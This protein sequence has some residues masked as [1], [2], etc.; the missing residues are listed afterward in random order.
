MRAETLQLSG[1]V[2]SWHVQVQSEAPSSR[3]AWVAC[4]CSPPVH[5]V[6]VSTCVHAAR[7]SLHSL[8]QYHTHQGCVCGSNHPWGMW[9]DPRNVEGLVAD[10]ARVRVL[11][12]LLELVLSDLIVV[13]VLDGLTIAE[14]RIIGHALCILR[15]NLQPWLYSIT[16][17]CPAQHRRI[18]R[19]GCP[20]MHHCV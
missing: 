7:K 10:D 3:F 19:S 18:T 13:L 16:C 20:R 2:A 4:A 5:V 12:V 17:V 8:R 6:G 9:R 11:Q 14:Q 1:F 15:A